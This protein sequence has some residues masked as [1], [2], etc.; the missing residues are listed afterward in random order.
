MKKRMKKWLGC[1]AA[2][3]M[4]IAMGATGFARDFDTDQNL[5]FFGGSGTANVGVHSTG[6]ALGNTV[7]FDKVILV[8]DGG[9]EAVD[10]PYVKWKYTIRPVL[11]D[12]TVDTINAGLTPNV[13]ATYKKGTTTI[14]DGTNTILVEPGQAAQITGGTEKTAEF[15]ADTYTMPTAVITAP[16]VQTF[17]KTVS[18]SFDTTKFTKAGVYRFVITESLPEGAN[19]D[20]VEDTG[21][22]GENGAGQQDVPYQRERFLDVYVRSKDTAG[23]ITYEI[24][25][26][27]MHSGDTDKD[28]N[29]TGNKW[30]LHK[31][32]GFDGGKQKG[33]G[34]LTPQGYTKYTPRKVKIKK[35][36]SGLVPT[37]TLFPFTIQLL[38]GG[39]TTAANDNKDMEIKVKYPG[40][41]PTAP[42]AYQIMS[43]DD[44]NAAVR[45][46][47]HD[48]EVEIIGLPKSTTVVVKEQ[49]KNFVGAVKSDLTGYKSIDLID[50]NKDTSITVATK[51]LKPDATSTD[52]DSFSTEVS[53]PLTNNDLGLLYHNHVDEITPTGVVLTVVPYAMMIFVS[54]SMAFMFLTKRKEE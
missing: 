3:I 22:K 20:D 48:D 31:N 5:S 13:A 10:E 51:V 53:K 33:N 28:N 50:A 29:A 47:K 4:V 40:F 18:F 14:S 24:Y 16:D 25:G 26:Y 21:G 34:K 38:H 52:P 46:L 37:D 19:K 15:K 54:I 42:N 11:D 35:K 41:T 23:A 9:T 45:N 12:G 1:A 2:A 39:A 30:A 8:E 6:Q 32:S 49:N 17:T 43:V 27:V 7:S 44:F 36:I